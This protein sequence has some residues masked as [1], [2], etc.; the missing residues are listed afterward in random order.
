MSCVVCCQSSSRGFSQKFSL[1]SLHLIFPDPAI[2]YFTY[3]FN[4]LSP[5]CCIRNAPTAE[6]SSPIWHLLLS[7]EILFPSFVSH[8]DTLTNQLPI[9]HPHPQPTTPS[10]TSE[11]VNYPQ[12]QRVT[13][14]SQ[15][16]FCFLAPRIHIPTLPTT[17]S[18]G[19]R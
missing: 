18:K 12:R 1:S 8:Y 7:F 6:L 14:G 2:Q 15:L 11:A 17:H 3:I 13:T 10:P 19:M 9:L 4:S 16:V 5:S